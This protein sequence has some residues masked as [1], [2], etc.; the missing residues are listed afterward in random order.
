MLSYSVVRL[1]HCINPEIHMVPIA[2]AAAIATLALGTGAAAVT[3][4]NKDI[5]DLEV[6]EKE[7]VQEPVL[8]GLVFFTTDTVVEMPE[9]QRAETGRDIQ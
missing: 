1:F 5:P 7:W 2:Q 3:A 9:Y 8:D 4:L 6:P